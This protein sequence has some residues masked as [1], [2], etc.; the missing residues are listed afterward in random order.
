ME[1]K[2]S[3]KQKCEINKTKIYRY[4]YT[5]ENSHFIKKIIGE[6]KLNQSMLFFHFLFRC[7]LCLVSKNQNNKKISQLS[8]LHL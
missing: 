1:I 4:I 2:K 8:Q 7:C 3:K 5:V 6:K